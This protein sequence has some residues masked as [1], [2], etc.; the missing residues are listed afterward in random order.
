MENIYVFSHSAVPQ[1]GMAVVL[2]KRMV[3]EEIRAQFVALLLSAKRVRLRFLALSFF[4]EFP[5]ID[6]D[7]DLVNGI[8]V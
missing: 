8:L 3:L 5:L 1:I 6:P 2:F 4:L 7:E